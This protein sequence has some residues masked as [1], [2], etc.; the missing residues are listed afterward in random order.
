MAVQLLDPDT[1]PTGDL[2]CQLSI[3]SGSRTIY[4][5]GQIARTAD[6]APVGPGDLAAQTEQAF[7]NLGAALQA[8]GATFD[9]VA[10]LTIYLVDWS[11]E[12]FADFGAGVQR[13]APRLAGNLRRPTTLLGVAALGE[14]DLLIEIE[15]IAVLD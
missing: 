12:K 2:Y 15:A 14:P 5:A 1:L 10:K 8:A 9:D 11:P 4:V 13:A 6:G 3:A 7:L